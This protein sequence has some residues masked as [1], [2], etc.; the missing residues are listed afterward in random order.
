MAGEVSLVNRHATVAEHSN[1]G[2]SIV[3]ER[4]WWVVVAWVPIAGMYRM[5]GET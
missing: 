4:A 1:S 5:P 2:I 3:G